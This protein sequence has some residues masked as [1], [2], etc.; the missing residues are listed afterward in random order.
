[1]SLSMYDAS[2][3]AF[4]PILQALDAILDKAAADATARK[5]DPVVFLGYRLAPDMWALTRQVQITC[6]FAK[7]G[8][9]RLAGIEPPKVEDTETSIPELKARI[10]KTLELI[11]GFKP[12]Q[13]DG[14]EDRDI[15]IPIGGQ[16][17]VF[18]GKRYL[19]HFVLPNFHFHATAA[20]AILRHCG[21]S[22][23]KRDFLGTF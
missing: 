10:A 13:I 18:K 5:I 7:N 14:S 3:T 19:V 12:E 6:D 20:Y 1:M 8:T 22:L 15:T 21:V 2:V 17:T 9:F 23:N 16:P 11:K 4:G